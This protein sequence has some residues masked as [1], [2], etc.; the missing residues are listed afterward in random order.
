MDKVKQN[1][2]FDPRS[3]HLSKVFNINLNQ[4]DDFV[5]FLSMSLGT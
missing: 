3:T 4:P 5:S 2:I 1:N